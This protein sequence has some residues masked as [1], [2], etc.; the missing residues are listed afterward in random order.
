MT[1]VGKSRK[2]VSGY[3]KVANIYRSCDFVTT[4]YFISSVKVRRENRD[5]RLNLDASVL[6]SS[7]ATLTL[8]LYQHTLLVLVLVHHH[9]RA[10]CTCQTHFGQV[11][12]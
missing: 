11:Q 6:S 12:M 10:D 2:V 1:D 4:I 7:K 8:F 9:C 3:I 5:C